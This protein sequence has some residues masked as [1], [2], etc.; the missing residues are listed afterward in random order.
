VREFEAKFGA[1]VTKRDIFHYVYAVLHH[2]RS[3]CQEHVP[4][5][6]VHLDWDVLSPEQQKPRAST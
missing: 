4:V 1:G 6:M 2:P 3:A 5:E